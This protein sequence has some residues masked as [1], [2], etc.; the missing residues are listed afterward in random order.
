[1]RDRS[2]ASSGDPHE[3]AVNARDLGEQLDDR[4]IARPRVAAQ[5]ANELGEPSRVIVGKAL[6]AD[7]LA[8]QPKAGLRWPHGGPPL[9]ADYFFSVF[10]S[11]QAKAFIVTP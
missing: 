9:T 11:P 10:K 3:G 1:M 4:H 5:N 8:P 6:G 2:A 7:R